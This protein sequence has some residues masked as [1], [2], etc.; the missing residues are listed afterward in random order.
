MKKLFTGFQWVLFLAH[1]F[2]GSGWA[3]KTAFD[4]VT[5]K[6]GDIHNGT[7]ARER[8]NLNTPYGQISIPYAQ[9][10]SLQTNDQRLT[11]IATL[12]G[13]HFSGQLTDEQF[14]MLR[15]L[16]PYLPVD[17]VSIR[18]VFFGNRKFRSPIFQ[19]PDLVIAQNG[20]TFAARVLTT[21]FL[22]MGKDGVLMLGLDA[23]SYLDITPTFEGEEKVMVQATQSNGQISLGGLS[24]KTIR[25]RAGYGAMLE[26][27]VDKLSALVLRVNHSGRRSDYLYRQRFNPRDLVQDKMRDGRMGPKLIALRGGKAQR[28]DIQGGGDFDE[29]PSH[30]VSIKPFAIGLHEVT[31]EEYDLYCEAT[32][33]SKPD[34]QEWGRGQRPV[35]NI[36]WEEAIA[37]TEWL[38]QRLNQRYR[39]PTDAEWEYA[40]RAGQASRY[41]WGNEVGQSKANCEGCGS[42]WDGDKTAPVARFEPNAFGLHDTAGNVFEWVADCWHDKFAEAPTDGSALD[43]P[44]CGKRVIRGGAWS[45]PPHE[46]RSANRWRDFPSRRS[47]DT[48]FRVARDLK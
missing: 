6:N 11:R 48:G 29:K 25:L 10:A 41:W 46:I 30:A 13:D 26:V 16:D 47:D 28:G 42:L 23:I 20:D 4:V 7:L 12:A 24:A 34:D 17:S 44:N 15:G 35:V 36:S 19:S 21:N 5:M 9:M 1:L 8:F 18:D 14:I 27:P 22:M 37:Y 40:A 31:F 2:A 43:K 39:L 3:A 45:F 38:S 33:K 32:G